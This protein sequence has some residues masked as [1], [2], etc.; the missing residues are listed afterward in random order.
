MRN[1]S[2]RLE[3][4]HRARGLAGDQDRRCDLALL[5]RLEGIGLPHVH[6]LRLDAEALE[7]V[8]RGKLRAGADV[9]EV[10]LLAREVGERADAAVRA[11]DQV[12]LFIEQLGDVDDLVVDRADLVGLLEIRQQVRLRDAEIDTLEEPHV[13]DVLPAAL[14]DHRQDAE[15]VAVVEHRR[16]VVRDRHVGGVGIARHDRDRVGIDALADAAELRLV[17]Q[18]RAVALRMRRLLRALTAQ[19]AARKRQ[20]DFHGRASGLRR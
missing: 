9:G 2:C 15:F 10:H 12:H 20:K 7:N 11:H 18:R 19:S 16:H 6:F 3:L 13:L 1:P 5:Q 4:R 17:R 14:A 8:A